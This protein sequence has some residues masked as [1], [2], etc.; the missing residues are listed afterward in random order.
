MFLETVLG[1]NN[2]KILVLAYMKLGHTDQYLQRNSLHQTSCK[3]SDV[4]FF[5][6]RAFSIITSKDEL[7]KENARIKQVLKENRYQESIS[8]IFKGVINNHSLTQSQ[9]RTAAPTSKE[10]RSE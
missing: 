5:F 3:K 6:N 7:N 10:E 4:A 9:E 2:G 1:M 8:K